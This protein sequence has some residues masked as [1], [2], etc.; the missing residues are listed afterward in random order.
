MKK[1]FG[2]I[3]LSFCFIILY[4]IFIHLSKSI[5]NETM[6]LVTS[7][8]VL[9]EALRKQKIT[10]EEAATKLGLSRQTIV[11]Y[12]RMEKLSADFIIKVKERLGI[13]LTAEPGQ[14]IIALPQNHNLGVPLFDVDFSEQNLNLIKD[15]KDD[16][17][18]VAWLRIPE[19]QGCDYIVKVRG[20]AMKD[21]INDEDY[22]GIKR[23]ANIDSAPLGY[24]YAVITKEYELIRFLRKGSN[25]D[26]FL[27]RSNNEV[28]EDFEI[29]KTDIKQL[30]T[31][32]VV[33]PFAKIKTLI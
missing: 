31:V 4:N 33:L 18:V 30:Y 9:K 15:L 17:H 6:Q 7:G 10:Q 12:I 23:I 8:E 32:R 26:V 20:D 21:L 24:V 5:E 22:I 1:D 16:S 19:V 27:A 3:N 14:Q 28:Y 11:N 13:D 25:R 2:K 29:P